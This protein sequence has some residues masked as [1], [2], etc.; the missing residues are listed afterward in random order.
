MQSVQT[1]LNETPQTQ[2]TKLAQRRPSGIQVQHFRLSQQHQFNN[3]LKMTCVTTAPYS[4]DADVYAQASFGIIIVLSEK[5]L[6]KKK[7]LTVTNVKD[8]VHYNKH[9]T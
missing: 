8:C 6:N 4:S 1:C 9:C 3:H 5:K 7:N 2:I